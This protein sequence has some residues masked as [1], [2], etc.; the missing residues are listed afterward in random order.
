MYKNNSI[1]VVVPAYN[2]EKKLS[3]VII[4]IPEFIDHIVIVDDA[5]TDDTFKIA[6]T[7]ED[8]RVCVIRH[9]INLGVGGAILTGHKKA[10][11]YGADI[12][13]VMAGDDQMN[14]QYLPTLLDPIIEEEYHYTKGNRFLKSNTLVGM[15][16]L[17]I[18]GNIIL[19]FLTKLASGYWHI[20]DPQNGYTAIRCNTLKELDF[21]SIA[22]RYEFENDMLINLNIGN[23]KVKDVFI[24]A[25]Y[26]DE[27]SKIQLHS[28]IGRTLYLL[29]IGFWK[30]ILIKYILRDFHPIALFLI[31]GLIFFSIGIIIGLYIVFSSIGPPLATAGTVML[32]IVPLFVGFQLILI[33]LV[34]DIIETSR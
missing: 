6:S 29:F 14:P 13:V 23:Y 22:K 8:E 28:F 24:P 2:E 16:K 18:F 26:S 3:N 7:V 34:L 31:F 9:K 15:P 33:A 32:S 21:D 17:R 10:I 11:E 30:R 4:K 1:C 12:S 19:T 20:F 25:H 27:E 5:S